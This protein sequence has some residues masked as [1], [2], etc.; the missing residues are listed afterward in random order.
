MQKQKSKNKTKIDA[1][2]L[3]TVKNIL[4]IYVYHARQFY[5]RQGGIRMDIKEATEWFSGQIKY[6]KGLAPFLRDDEEIEM[7]E[8]IQSALEKQMPKKPLHYN[9]DNCESQDCNGCEHMELCGVHK[10]PACRESVKKDYGELEF[11]LE[12]GQRIDWET[13]E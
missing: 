11:C 5:R 12:C 1:K 9:S 2:T 7:M 13:E 4:R 10:C 3:K 8:V 6:A